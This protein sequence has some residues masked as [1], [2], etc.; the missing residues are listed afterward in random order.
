VRGGGGIAPDVALP[1]PPSPPAWWIEVHDRGWIQEVADEAAAA[2]PAGADA[3][4]AWAAARSDHLAL[5]DSLVARARRELG[6]T[7]DLA[8]GIRAWIGRE[9]ASR[10][11]SVRWGVAAGARFRVAT[12]PDV[13]AAREI[14]PDWSRALAGTL[15]APAR[16]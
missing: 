5:A 2:L 3:V 10:V 8:P 16:K 6:L 15:P 1:G 11:A 4:D 9:I 12:D 14:F 7:A 13:E